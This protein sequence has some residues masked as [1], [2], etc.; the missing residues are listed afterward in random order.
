[1]PECPCCHQSFVSEVPLCKHF[2]DEHLGDGDVKTC[3]CAGRGETH[4]FVNSE[5]GMWGFTH[6]ILNQGGLVRHLLAAGLG[7]EHG[8]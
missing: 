1:M 2:W 7:V 8:P 6:H 5:H 3:P 4:R